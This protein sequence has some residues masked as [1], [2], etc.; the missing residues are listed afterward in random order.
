M[1]IFNRKYKINYD[2]L[3]SKLETGNENVISNL[4]WSPKNKTINHLPVSIE[5]IKKLKKIDKN[6]ELQI[7]KKIKKGRFELIIFKIPWT[8]GDIPFSPIIIDLSNSKIIGVILPFNELNAFLSGK[9]S[10][11]I[12]YLSKQWVNFVISYRSIKQTINN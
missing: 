3:I 8:D 9:E 12:R 11:S 6:Y 10:K 4:L 7:H 5:L 1:N 2:N